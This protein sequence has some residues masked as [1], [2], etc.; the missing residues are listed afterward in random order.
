MFYILAKPPKCPLIGEDWKSG[1][2]FNKSKIDATCCDPD[3]ICY[4]D[5]SD[6]WCCEEKL[7]CSTT[8]IDWVKKEGGILCPYDPIEYNPYILGA[9]AIIIIVFGAIGCFLLSGIFCDKRIKKKR[10]L[11]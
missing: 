9:T 4:G 3:E 7:F 11:N 5:L 6:R 2:K 10:A 8:G 1:K